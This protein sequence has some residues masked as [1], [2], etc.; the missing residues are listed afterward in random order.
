MLGSI[1]N[2]LAIIIGGILGLLLK[3]GIPERIS[4][5]I[6][7]G[8]ALCVFFIGVSGMLKGSNVLLII[9]S[10]VIG[11]IIGEVI[12][13][14]K[15]INNLGKKI[16]EKFEGKGNIS[17]AFVTTSLLYCVGAMAIVGS[18]QS[19]LEGNH[20]I[21]FAKSILDGISSIIF[22]STMGI[23]VLFSAFSVLLYQGAITLLAFTLKNILTTA[24]IN[25]M[26][27]IGSLLILGISLNM[28]KITN[29][30]IANLL[31]SVLIPIVYYMLLN[32]IK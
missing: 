30:K 29:I 7:E 1:V 31:P 16:E 4:K 10:I 19:G 13:I 27:S 25:E 15:L 32:L 14:D 20:K 11:G 24:T 8:L 18:L 28:L 26:T 5:T 3:K 6:I 23:G 21:L 2:F 12:D 22:A 17:E 9:F